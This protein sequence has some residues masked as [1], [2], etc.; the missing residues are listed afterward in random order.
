MREAL[1]GKIIKLVYL[2][3]FLI[4]FSVMDAVLIVIVILQAALTFFSDE[5]SDT[6]RNFG[7]SLSVYLKQIVAFLSY[8]SEQKPYPFSDWPDS[9][10]DSSDPA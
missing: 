9:E 5:P 2:I 6:L 1:E 7:S 10:I 3:L 4:I 8:A